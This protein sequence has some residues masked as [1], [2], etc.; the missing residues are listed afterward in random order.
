M[1]K[2]LSKTE[3]KSIRTR[4]VYLT[5][6]VREDE[7]EDEADG[8]AAGDDVAGEAGDEAGNDVAGEAGNEAGNEAAGN[9]VGSDAET[10]WIHQKDYTDE[11]QN[12]FV[13]DV[14]A[15]QLRDAAISIAEVAA[16][17]ELVA[18][19]AELCN[20]EQIRPFCTYDVG[21]KGTSRRSAGSMQYMVVRLRKMDG[22][23]S[24]IAA[25][26]GLKIKIQIKFD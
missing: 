13:V 17:E 20:I 9:E 25:V 2:K 22:G 23:K 12:D 6:V 18:F 1:L 10:F 16:A 8:E 24:S 14:S 3:L 19:V 15:L 11:Q 5:R 7:N 4:I 26:R 21:T